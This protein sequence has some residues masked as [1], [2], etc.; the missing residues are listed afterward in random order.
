[1]TSVDVPKT[2][3]IDSEVDHAEPAPA[4]ALTSPWA[5]RGSHPQGTRA[6]PHCQPGAGEPS[7]SPVI[8]GD[9]R[10]SPSPTHIII[11]S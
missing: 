5:G 10:L 2:E 4:A 1:M 7:L 11:H 6:R 8:A 3:P 9:G